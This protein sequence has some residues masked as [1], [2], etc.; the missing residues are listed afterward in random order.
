MRLRRSSGPF[1]RC[2][3]GNRRRSDSPLSARLATVMVTAT[4]MMTVIVAALTRG[5][6]Q[7]S[8]QPPLPITGWAEEAI[9]MVEVV[10]GL[11]AMLPETPSGQRW[12]LYCLQSAAA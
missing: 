9:E 5:W 8:L 10:L 7:R 3:S 4:M 6:R 12:R 2:W 11:L 1:Y